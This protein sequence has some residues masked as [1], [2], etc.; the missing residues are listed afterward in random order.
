MTKENGVVVLLV[1]NKHNYPSSDY[2]RSQAGEGKLPACC[3]LFT[4]SNLVPQRALAW[5]D[6]GD[7]QCQNKLSLH[8]IW[9]LEKSCVSPYLNLAPSSVSISMD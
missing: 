9:A 3:Y 6:G 4:N 1:G 7:P 8:E 2:T 5:Y